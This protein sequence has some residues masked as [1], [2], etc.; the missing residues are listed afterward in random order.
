MCFKQISQLGFGCAVGQIPN[1]KVLHRNSS[2]VKSS[3]LV[4]V[5]VGFAARPSESRGG[6]GMARIALLR[7][8]D[9]ERT[10]EIR[11]EASRMPHR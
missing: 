8:M 10:A 1:I 4:G 7:A 5:A 9:A 3:K 2:F 6:G 11:R